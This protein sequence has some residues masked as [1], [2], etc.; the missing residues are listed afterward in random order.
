[1]RFP[2]L[3][4]CLLLVHG[5]AWAKEKMPWWSG[6][7]PSLLGPTGLIAVPDAA[8]TMPSRIAVFAHRVNAGVDYWTSGA[9]L[10]AITDVG[11]A[12]P[13]GV[14]FGIA[15]FDPESP[16]KQ[17]VANLKVAVASGKWGLAVGAMDLTDQANRTLYFVGTRRIGY[18]EGS[19]GL[20]I[21]FGSNDTSKN[22][23]GLFVGLDLGILAVEHDGEDT[24]L[25]VRFGPLRAGWVGGYFFMGAA[26]H[27][28]F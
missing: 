27:S 1:M 12:A 18:R 14:E 8:T 17:T 24:N 11:L 25:G 9:N 16:A 28:K 22:L 3:I 26:A 4:C 15:V 20:T 2:T 19:A 5:T 21:G 7:Q 10:G 13:V 23:D 6:P